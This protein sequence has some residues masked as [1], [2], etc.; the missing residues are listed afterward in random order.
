MFL[1]KK[2]K[3]ASRKQAFAELQWQ[4]IKIESFAVF[5]Q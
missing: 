2:N 1:Q 5:F 4:N 3:R